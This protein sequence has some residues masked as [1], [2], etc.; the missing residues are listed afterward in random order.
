MKIQDIE[1]VYLRFDCLYM[2]EICSTYVTQKTVTFMHFSALSSP[3]LN[4]DITAIRLR[5]I[6]CDI[7]RP[8]RQ[9]HQRLLRPPARTAE[10]QASGAAFGWAISW[11]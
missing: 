6:L 4:D 11:L 9:A 8:E 1:L 7:H 2:L 10:Y 5:E 3:P